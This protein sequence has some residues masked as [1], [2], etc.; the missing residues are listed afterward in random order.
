MSARRFVVWM[1]APDHPQWSIPDAS[2]ER[3]G[4]A[5]GEG[6]E[7]DSVEVPLDAT[8]DGARDTPPEVLE[9]LADAEVYCGWGIRPEAFEAARELRWFHSG[10]AGVR[11]SLFDAMRESDVL[12]TNSAGVYAEPL[13]EHAL[14]GMLYFARGLDV[15]TRAQAERA[16]AQAELTA[17]DSPLK[18][19]RPAGEIQGAT[20]GILGYG[21]IGEALGRRAHALGMRVR[22]IRRTRGALPPELEALGGPEDLPK[23]LAASDFVAITLAETP[24]TI[25]M[26]GAREL[27]LMRPGAVLVNLA[28]GTIVDEEALVDALAERRLRGAVLDVFQTEPLP[29]DHPFWDLDNVLVTPHV[30]GTSGGFWERETALIV[31]NVRR[32]LAGEEL[33]NRVDKERGY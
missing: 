14:A 17:A 11:A 19:G 29:A 32:Y 3:I 20:L 28:R 25:Q 27:A 13:A 33:E 26:L 2:L 5:L 7:V 21:G 10:A 15:A 22:A 16:W 30:G 12:F 1:H 24:A 18:S 6:W 31:G 4:E 23:L 8:G 9:A